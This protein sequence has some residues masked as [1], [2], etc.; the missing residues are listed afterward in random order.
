MW[1]EYPAGLANQLNTI[2]EMQQ[3]INDVKESIQE[4]ETAMV[5][6]GNS[7][8]DVEWEHFDYLQEQ[9]SNIT[10]EAD[11]LIDLMD[12]SDLYTDNG[13]PTDVGTAVMGLH[14][15]NYNVYMAQAD[16]YAEE[17]L[18]LNK[19]I[20][21]D[22]Y[23]TTLLERREGLL[24]SQRESILAA[25]DE[26]Q[27][28]VDMVEE[29]INLEL[30]AL[31]DLIDE[32][33]DALD[34]S[35]SLYEYQKKIKEQASE[36]TSIEKQLAAYSGDDSE[37]TRATVQK[38]QVD[39]SDAME[40]LEE[41]EYD[42]YVSEQKKLLD[43]LYTEYET[44]L[45]ERLDNVD[46]LISDMISTIN[47]NSSTISDTIL[48]EADKVGYTISSD[49]QSIWA[50]NGSAVSII[51][52]YGNSFL[53]QMTSVND[54]I[55]KI[56]TKIDTMISL[57]DRIASGVTGETTSTTATTSATASIPSSTV[58][59]PTSVANS[60]PGSSSST[61]SSRAF[62]DDVMRGVAA[63]IWIAGSSASGWGDGTTRTQR[64]TEKFGATN[65][66]AIQ[67]YI[68]A[69]AN[70]GTVYQNWVRSGHGSLSQYYYS[71]FK[72]GGLADYT[73]V[74]W[75]DGTPSEPEMVLNAEDTAHFIALKDAMQSIA[76]GSSPLA[77]LFTGGDSSNVVEHLAAVGSPL[78]GQGTS[79]GNISYQI[80]IP[81]D[82]VQDYEDFMNQMRKDDKFEKMVQSAT[83]GR[84]TG[85]SRLTKNKYQW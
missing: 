35:Q 27:A 49:I 24:S 73:G 54:V 6:F 46:A 80:N 84:L 82:H 7:I 14:G 60:T 3:K 22:P 59:L 83:I 32:Y 29:G 40:D 9:I 55:S 78:S 66:S 1:G 45:N 81:I 25:E 72:N 71:A 50:N 42:R 57:S 18:E 56:S 4:S 74:A 53:T 48:A 36:I 52:E 64:L 65:A 15:Q 16:K 31:S 8:R 44:I 62:S 38:L 23:N 26:K 77:E 41:T 30:D 5:E 69:N 37:E 76:D 51:S 63:A 34:E 67:S 20:A 13:Q 70:N 33:E 11:F 68:N 75:L 39:L 47:T 21:E 17:L 10:E 28:I 2:D 43:N 19:E 85:D 61:S 79:V 58:T 12:N